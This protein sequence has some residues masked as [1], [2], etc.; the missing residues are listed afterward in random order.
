MGTWHGY[1]VDRGTA[2]LWGRQGH[3]AD[4]DPSELCRDTPMSQPPP[5]PNQPHLPP[6]RGR[7]QNFQPFRSPGALTSSVARQ[8]S[9]RRVPL[10][11]SAAAAGQHPGVPAPHR[12]PGAPCSPAAPHQRP[13]TQGR[14]WQRGRRLQGA[15]LCLPLAWRAMAA[16][17][18]SLFAPSVSTEAQSG[19]PWTCPLPPGIREASGSSIIA[20]GNAQSD[21]VPPNPTCPHPPCPS[22][23][24]SLSPRGGFRFP[25]VEEGPSR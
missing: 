22:G 24:S 15:R 3:S 17:T 21:A 23:A 19:T 2:R 16:V 10:R 25:S 7:S 4:P 8:T 14:V 5:C 9:G 18:P 6:R 13:F 11:T 1:G 20:K 12:A